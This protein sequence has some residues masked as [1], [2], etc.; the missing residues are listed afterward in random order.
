[1]RLARSFPDHVISKEALEAEFARELK[2]EDTGRRAYTI[3]EKSTRKAVG[4]ATIRTH[5]FTR[6]ATSA[7]IGLALGEKSAWNKG[8]GTETSKLLLDEVFRQLNLHRVEWWTFSENIASIQLAKKLGFKEEARL[9]D[10]VFFD[11]HYHD[12]IVFGLLK[13]E[14]ESIRTAPEASREVKTVSYLQN[15]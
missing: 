5:Q 4:W 1:M 11:N 10:S 2:G 6:R 3:E 9:R 14:F 8:Y 7:D 15:P 13:P 12:L